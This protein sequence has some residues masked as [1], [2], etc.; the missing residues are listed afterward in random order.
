[1]NDSVNGQS[2]I[3]NRILSWQHV[4]PAIYSPSIHVYEEPYLLVVCF[5]S[6]APPGTRPIH[7]SSCERSA[8]MKRDTTSRI[9]VQ[10]LSTLILHHTGGDSRNGLDLQGSPQIKVGCSRACN[11][12]RG[13][14]VK[15]KFHEVRTYNR[16][17]LRASQKCQ[18]QGRPLLPLQAPHCRFQAFIFGSSSSSS[19][20]KRLRRDGSRTRL[21]RIIHNPCCRL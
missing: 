18:N 15:L 9:Q 12:M 8:A 6:I 4:Q 7:P 19:P 10:G 3:L 2:P 11:E 1:M 17:R 13:S 16:H 14:R 21:A 5:C 20:Q